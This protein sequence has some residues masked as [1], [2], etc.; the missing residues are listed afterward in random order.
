MEFPLQNPVLL[1]QEE[2]L[3]LFLDLCFVNQAHN[4]NHPDED[5]GYS[6]VIHIPSIFA[7]FGYVPL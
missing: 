4:H 6:L 1:T 7:P 3:N 2:W 5:Y